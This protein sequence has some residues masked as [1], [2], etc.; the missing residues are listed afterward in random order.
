MFRAPLRS[1]F[2][3]LAVLVLSA[4]SF[5][6]P[7]SLPP[8]PPG[9]GGRIISGP[10]VRHAP[11][12]S[13]LI[14]TDNDPGFAVHPFFRVRVYC[15][16]P[17]WDEAV[18]HLS[19]HRNGSLTALALSGH[20]SHEGGISTKAPNSHLSYPNLSDAHAAVIRAKLRPGAPILL[21]GCHTATSNN[22]VLLAR[23]L[24]RP[25]I[26]NTGTVRTNNHGEGQWVEFRP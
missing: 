25:V 17:N 2:A 21:L 23:K 11:P 20:G 13:V 1:A 26:A 7:P 4:A 14:S 18:R 5:A 6:G 10:G 19:R 3:L 8:G 24:Q 22:I 9:A 12:G 16:V 15:R